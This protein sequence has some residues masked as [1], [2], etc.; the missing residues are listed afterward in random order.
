MS[1]FLPAHD[2]IAAG[3]AALSGG[4]WLE[5]RARF[6]QALARA[7]APEALEGMG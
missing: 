6:Q 2:P 5:A 3:R 1:E 7:S 4:R